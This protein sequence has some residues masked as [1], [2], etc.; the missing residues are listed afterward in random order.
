MLCLLK[1]DVRSKGGIDDV[2]SSSAPSV[3]VLH[4]SPSRCKHLSYFLPDV[5]SYARVPFQLL[6]QSL[7]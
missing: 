5:A 4:L 7:F 1:K 6:L 3:D 2:L